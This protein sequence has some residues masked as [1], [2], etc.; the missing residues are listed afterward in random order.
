M[1]TNNV[2]NEGTKTA[3]GIYIAQGTSTPVYTTLTNGQL[4][5]GNTGND[6]TAAS[7]T[8]GT[9][10]TVTPGAGTITI[11]S[12]A[13]TSGLTLIATATAS[14]SATID[15]AGNLSATYDNYMVEIEDLVA[16]SA[17]PSILMLVGTGGGPTY[18]TTT[19]AGGSF[20][21]NSSS[22]TVNGALSLTTSFRL[23][24][25]NASTGTYVSGTSTNGSCLHI[26]IYNTQNASNYKGYVCLMGGP[27][28]DNNLGNVGGGCSVSGG[29]WSTATALTALRFQMSTGN[30]STGKFKLYGL[31]N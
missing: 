22:A 6:P 8:A 3:H 16:V 18:S 11:A 2:T 1:A 7:I 25:A 27:T 15:F 12:S 29:G 13:G 9:G 26:R 24:C 31:T 23:N 30:I 5:I 10:I 20:G 17:G 4:L 28:Y 14:N 21:N 19:Y